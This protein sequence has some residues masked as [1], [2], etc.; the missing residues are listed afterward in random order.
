MS[1]TVRMSRLA[2]CRELFIDDIQYGMKILAMQERSSLVLIDNTAI[3]TSQMAEVLSFGSDDIVLRNQLFDM[4]FVNT[5][6]LANTIFQIGANDIAECIFFILLV[7][8]VEVAAI[9]AETVVIGIEIFP[10]LVLCSQF[11]IAF[12]QRGNVFS[13]VVMK[14]GIQSAFCQSRTDLNAFDIFVF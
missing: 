12:I 14:S 11:T 10:C 2:V 4:R 7:R 5:E 3:T 8:E 13:L 6:F 1:F 9:V